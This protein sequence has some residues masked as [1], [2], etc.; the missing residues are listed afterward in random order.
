MAN[1][2]PHLRLITVRPRESRA[3]LQVG[4]ATFPC[5]IGRSGI[6][7]RKREGDGA[8]PIGS[9]PIRR[10]LYRADKLSL[11]ATGLENWAIDRHDGWCD[12]PADRRYNLPVRL[13]YGAS[14]ESLW[15]DDDLYDVVVVLGQNDDP[16]IPGLG[17]A[18][19][20]HVARPDYGPTEGCV[21]LKREDLLQVLS[22]VTP[23]TRLL[24][25]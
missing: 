16:V 20:M 18:I 24:V 15:R 25:G 5:A 4:T 23:D 1:S 9:W 14:T 6:R 3:S 11:P 7:R 8:T 2:V 17:S 12:A 19:F 13:P 22:R 10:V 21:A